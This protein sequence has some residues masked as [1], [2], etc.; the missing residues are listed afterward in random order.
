M[1]TLFDMPLVKENNLLRI[2][3]EIHDYIYSHDGLSPQE[4]LEEFVKILF[5]KLFD[6]SNK[7]HKFQLYNDS[8]DVID[9]TSIFEL[10]E[11]T[12]N[13]F[14][15]LFDAKDK[16]NLSILSIRFIVKKLQNISLGNSSYDVKGLAFQK[17][18]SS[19]EKSGRGQFFT[20][21]PV[22]NF[23][24]QIIAP[25]K[26]EKILDPACGTGGFLV[27][28]LKYLIKDNSDLDAEF[29]I[30][31][32]LFGIEINKSIARIAKMKLL[33]EQNTN[34]NIF[35]ANSLEV[36]NLIQNLFHS[37]DK[38][39]IILTNPPFGAKM[40]QENILSDY[41]LGYKW[42]KTQNGFVKNNTVLNSQSVEILFIERCIDLLKTGGRMAVVLPNG[43]FE[44][45]SLEYIRYFIMKKTRILAVVNLPQET[46]IP[47]GTGVKTSLLFLEK[48]DEHNTDDYRI[49][50]GK[51]TKLGY[52]GNKNGTPI[53]KKNKYGKIM[54][55]VTGT[56][57]IDEDI[58]NIIQSYQNYISNK[59]F[60]GDNVFAINSNEIKSRFDFDYYSPETKNLFVNTNNN[61][62][63]LSDICKILKTKSP[64]LKTDT[65][66]IDYIELSDINTYSFEIV[67]TTVYN[68]HNLPSRASYELKEGD[69]ITAVAGNSVGTQ[70]HA[71]ALVSKKHA[72]CIC[73]N[74]FRVLRNLTINPYY[75]LYYMKT[76]KFLKQMFA[77]RTGAAIPSV[78]DTDM[79]SIIIEIPQNEIMQNIIDKMQHIFLL[80]NK[81]QEEF[82]NIYSAGA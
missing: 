65:G 69:I 29:I 62:V 73:T 80:R 17:F 59:E 30:Q 58:S 22:I 79:N 19:H 28:A 31:Q 49:F 76:E 75:L 72:G 32:N 47:Y 9:L 25:Q 2:F 43:N 54:L 50:F 40:H 77:F 68:I 51:I 81:A 26:H 74:G 52:H 66:L 39:D 42:H 35:S 46:F 12:K 15:T 16:I 27:S 34:N 8:Y 20:P 21:E 45:S 37:V 55:D 10:F 36:I 78:S 60:A 53:Y 3:E 70:K 4:T 44:N 6:E 57:I 18:L 33:L 67:N 7:L 82:E 24:I 64:K 71:S 61:T 38:F 56:Q 48:K 63:K 5:I 11:L 1:N 13:K 14:N 41:Q 23:C